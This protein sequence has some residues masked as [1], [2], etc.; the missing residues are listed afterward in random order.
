MNIDLIKGRF[1]TSDAMS[2]ISNMIDVKIK[3]EEEKILGSDN[4]EDIKMR[5]SRIKTLQK[6]LSESRKLVE[7][8]A[9]LVSLH[10][11]IQLG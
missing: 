1:K 11:E 10:S 6:D 8:Q 9:G 3:F 4:E 5:E 7:A 2:I